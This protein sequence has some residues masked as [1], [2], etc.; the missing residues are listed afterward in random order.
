[1]LW[2]AALCFESYFYLRHAY[3]FSQNVRG[4]KYNCTMNEIKIRNEIDQYLRTLKA[5]GM[6]ETEALAFA[7][8]T[9]YS[10]LT[11]DQIDDLFAFL[12]RV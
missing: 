2:W 11:D 8:A 4:I 10:L 9:A 5:K 6:S 7:F 1:M 3:E 12:S